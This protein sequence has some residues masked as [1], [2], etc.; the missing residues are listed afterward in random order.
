M[1]DYVKLAATAL[2]LVE[3]NGRTVQFVKLDTTPLADSTKPWRGTS[4]PRTTPDATLDLKAVV[5]G[6]TSLG[7]KTTVSD[8]LKKSEQIMIVAT[9]QDLSQ[10]NEIVDNS[11]RWKIDGFEK[12]AP[13]GTTILYFVGVSQ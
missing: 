5:V 10:Y 2:R 11:R 8:F 1:V 7:F 3:K 9:T 12:L 6:P 4:N 13:A